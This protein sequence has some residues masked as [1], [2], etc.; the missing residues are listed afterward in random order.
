MGEEWNAERSPRPDPV[1]VAYGF[2]WQEARQVGDMFFEEC[3]K[4]ITTTK[5]GGVLVV[6]KYDEAIG[7]DCYNLTTTG[8][9]SMTMRGKNADAEHIPCVIVNTLIFD[10]AQVTSRLNYS[11][12]RWG[13][14]ATL[15]QAQQDKR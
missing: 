12:P 4:P 10:R 5:P 9:V 6:Q 8:G 14:K 2:D 3:A 15:S 1:R 13:G 7:V 11:R